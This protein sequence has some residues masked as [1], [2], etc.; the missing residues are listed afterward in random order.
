MAASNERCPQVAQINQTPRSVG[1]Q[2]AVVARAP[3]PDYGA[4]VVRQADRGNGLTVASIMSYVEKYY[5]QVVLR[6]VSLSVI[7]LAFGNNLRMGNY[8]TSSPSEAFV[9]YR[10][11]GWRR[12]VAVARFGQPDP[13]SGAQPAARFWATHGKCAGVSQA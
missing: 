12:L 3:H 4:V 1:S 10:L 8:T 9:V 7:R 6:L 5:V 11:V 13:D 2:P